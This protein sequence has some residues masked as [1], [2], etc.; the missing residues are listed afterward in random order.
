MNILNQ[1]VESWY[2][3][4]HSLQIKCPLCQH[5]IPNVPPACVTARRDTGK[6][7]WLDCACNTY[8][9]QSAHGAASACTCVG[10]YRIACQD[11]SG[12]YRVV[13]V[14][15]ATMQ[16]RIQ[17]KANPTDEGDFPIIGVPSSLNTCELPCSHVTISDFVEKIHQIEMLPGM[18][19]DQVEHYKRRML[20]FAESLGSQDVSNIEVVEIQRQ[21]LTCDDLIRMGIISRGVCCTS[22][23]DEWGAPLH[24]EPLHI[25][26]DGFVADVCCR[27]RDIVSP[28][29]IRDAL[30]KVWA[31]A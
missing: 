11:T 2:A 8:N 23:H 12:R 3:A 28:E 6:T 31:E 20:G 1:Y 16:E 14:D 10:R 4:D 9:G 25:E 19:A 27:V 30:Q 15:Y 7:E 21:C 18:N 29:M 13:E 5:W 17:A 26:G 24:F 22:C